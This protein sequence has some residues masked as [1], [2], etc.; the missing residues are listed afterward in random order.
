[1]SDCRTEIE[2][3]CERF[4]Q[5]LQAEENKAPL[6]IETYSKSLRLVCQLLGVQTLQAIDRGSVR[7]LK[8][9]LHSYRTGRGE[10]LSVS[11]KNHHLTILRTFLRYLMR[12]EELDVYPPD[13]IRRLKAGE[14]KIKVV[15]LEQ[16][17]ALLAAPDAETRIGKRDRAIMELFFSTGLRLE[18]LRQLNRKDINFKTR[19]VPVRGKGRKLRVVF[20]TDN[21]DDAV[22]TY[23]KARNDHLEPLFI[24]HDKDAY[25]VLPPGDEFRLSRTMIGSLVK[26]YAASVGISCDP[27]PHTLRHCFATQMLAGGADLRSV[28]EQL[29]HKDLSTT[30]LYTHV[31]NPQLKEVHRRCHPGQRRAA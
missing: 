24:R 25:Y 26:K 29:G 11:T 16:L 4:L 15:S 22:R 20:L 9:R 6:T 14:R 19:E 18:E 23:L 13:R 3:A 7:L 21:A 12:E 30:Q 10:E 2:L 5:H 1:M 31:T 17:G 27:S 8:Q 28:Q